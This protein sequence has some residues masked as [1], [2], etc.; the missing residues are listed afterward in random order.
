MKQCFLLR[1]KTVF[2]KIYD[3]GKINSAYFEPCQSIKY[4]NQMMVEY[5]FTPIFHKISIFLLQ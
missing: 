1:L 4:L 3:L 2:K 5:S